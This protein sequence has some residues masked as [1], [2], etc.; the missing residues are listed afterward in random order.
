MKI[1]YLVNNICQVGGIERVICQLATY[2][3]EQ[4]NYIVEVHSIYS[5]SEQNTY[6]PCSEKVRFVH[7]NADWR[8][9]SRYQQM[10]LIRKIMSEI[11]ADILITSHSPISIAAILSKR[12]FHGKLIV[13]EHNMHENY[14]RKRLWMNPFF[15]HFADQLILLTKHDL[16]Y[17]KASG[18][19]RCSVIPNAVSIDSTKSSSINEECFVSTG[20]MEEVK[21][22]GMLLSAFAEAHKQLPTWK[23]KILGDGSKREQLEAQI[24]SNGLQ[25]SVFLPGFVKDVQSELLASS[26][27]VMSSRFEGFSLALIEAM[28][29]GLPCISFAI[30]PSIEILGNDAGVLVA[31]NDTVALADAMVQIATSAKSRQDYASRAKERVSAF[32]LE[33]ICNIWRNLFQMI[34]RDLK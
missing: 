28:A 33:E 7:Y 3:T 8:T 1:A 10:R 2:F 4:I 24:K 30:P 34:C 13:T 5:S 15:Y 22:F 21:G 16:E 11:N 26:V 12:V 14:T 6:F 25:D 20:R 27:Y 18:A 9:V 23:L 29:C 31:C 17:Y 32:S 19:T